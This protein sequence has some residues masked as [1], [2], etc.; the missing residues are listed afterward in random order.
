MAKERDDEYKMTPT[1]YGVGYLGIGEFRARKESKGM[2][3]EYVMW[4]NMLSRCYGQPYRDNPIN[5][6]RYAECTVCEEWHNFQ[7]FAKW[8]N[9]QPN[10][11]KP[12]YS[13]DKDLTEFG[14]TLYCPEKCCIVAPRV[15][16]IVKMLEWKIDSDLP[17]GVYRHGG[18]YSSQYRGE[19]KYSSNDVSELHNWYIEKKL[20]YLTQ[21]AEDYRHEITEVIYQN[22]LNWAP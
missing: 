19:C 17:Q 5:S 18:G 6:A 15:N 10:F 12:R 2:T 4:T 14:N 8:C 11:A 3:K 13:L 21:I 20:E 9:E 1:V 7:N 16:S 22:L